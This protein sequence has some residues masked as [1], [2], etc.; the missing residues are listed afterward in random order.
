MIRIREVVRIL[1]MPPM[2]T[3]TE[4]FFQSPPGNDPTLENPVPVAPIALLLDTD[5]QIGRRIS[6]DDEVPCRALWRE[7]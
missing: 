6:T 7:Q 5:P 4:V 3:G 2:P 1:L